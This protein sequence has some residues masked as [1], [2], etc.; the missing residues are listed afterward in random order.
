MLKLI[1]DRQYC[2]RTHSALRASIAGA[3]SLAAAVFFATGA[4]AQGVVD[5]GPFSVGIA[6]NGNL[7]LPDPDGAG[8]GIAIGFRRE[9]DGYDPVRPRLPRDSWGL[10]SSAGVAFADPTLFG[11]SGISSV[12]SVF[13]PATASY[14][15]ATTFDLDIEMVFSFAADNILQI[16]TSVM[17]NS[18][19]TITDVVFQ[20]NVDWDI[21][22]TIANENTGAFDQSG[23]PNLVDLSYGGFENPN[24]MVAYLL[25]CL[26]GCNETGDLGGG[27]KV[28]LGDIDPGSYSTVTYFYGINKIGDDAFDLVDQVTLAGAQNGILS[29]SSENGE[30]DDLGL[31]SAVLAISEV[32]VNVPAP[33]L[34]G[35]LSGLLA[36]AFALFFAAGRRRRGPLGFVS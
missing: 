26:S 25:S 32:Q 36:G 16:V 15:I 20:R 3:A 17:N 12:T 11:V 19:V 23:E 34:A 33:A 10:S 31:N 7:F 22:P 2:G 13:G 24:P 30:F 1:S 21:R 27:V 5:S 14:H 6:A 18:A 4:Q 8:P 9:S 35:G 28:S 29:Q